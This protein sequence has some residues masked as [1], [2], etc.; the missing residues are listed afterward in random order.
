MKIAYGV[1]TGIE[2]TVTGWPPSRVHWESSIVKDDFKVRNSTSARN[3]VVA[4]KSTFMLRSPSFHYDGKN[5]ACVA[6]PKHGTSL[7]RGF[8]LKYSNGR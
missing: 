8:T 4:V 1:K 7:R 3:G 2:C 6:V 5:V